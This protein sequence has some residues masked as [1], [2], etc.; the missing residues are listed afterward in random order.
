M[1]IQEILNAIYANHIYEYV[2][3]DETYRV[4]EFS[5]KVFELC[6]QRAKE[7]DN[8][9]ITDLVPELY[10][11]ETVLE[12]I[13]KGQRHAFTIPYVQ[14]SLHKDVYIHIHVHPGRRRPSAD[15][16]GRVYE[17]M[18]VLFENVTD[19]AQTQQKLIQERNEKSLL[20]DD[21]SQ[22]NAQLKRFNEEMQEIVDEEIKKNM[23]KQKL[24]EL[25]ARHAQMGEMIGMITHQWKQPLNVISLIVNVLKLNLNKRTLSDDEVNKKLDDTLKQVRYMDQTVSDFQSFFNPSRER[26]YFN[27]YD[28][29][30]TIIDLVQF[31]YSH[32]H[33]TLELHGNEKL[34]AYGY[35]NEFNQVVLTLL[36][37]AR[38]AYIENPQDDMR[39]FIDIKEDEGR[40]CVTVR[41]NAGGIREDVM[42]KIFDL[43]VTTKP[44]GS[45]I[46]LNIAKNM[47]E[48]N[49]QGKLLVRNVD[50]GAEFTI[51]LPALQETDTP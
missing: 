10:G 13:L 45:G 50:G 36:N 46:G 33:I 25:Q 1:H 51:L 24:V 32:N 38:D 12:E 42:E 2:V 17:S 7:C 9:D 27:L 21:I 40:P 35:P 14:K 5:D 20:L 29:I 30:K 18:V 4:I 41:D 28:S 37:N 22:K 31:E 19:M 8:I 3:V 11:L 48:N 44:K 16:Q 15:E 49:M 34:L 6:S 39:I 26:I 47:V 43:Y 23:E